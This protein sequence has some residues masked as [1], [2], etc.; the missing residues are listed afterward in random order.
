[1]KTQLM[2]CPVCHEVAAVVGF[3]CL[4]AAPSI[5][6]SAPRHPFSVKASPIELVVAHQPHDKEFEVEVE[7]TLHPG[8]EIR[9]TAFGLNARTGY[10]TL[11]GQAA[12]LLQA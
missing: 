5:H 10:L 8:S 9:P 11:T 6:E 7:M 1:M 4:C 3:A 2:R 12:S